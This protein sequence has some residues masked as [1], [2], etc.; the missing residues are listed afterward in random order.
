MDGSPSLEMIKNAGLALRIVGDSSSIAVSCGVYPHDNSDL[1]EELVTVLSA[2]LADAGS[3]ARSSHSI[4]WTLNRD[5]DL[6]EVFVSRWVN[7]GRGVFVLWHPHSALPI[8][9]G[10]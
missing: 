7:G 3:V 6:V 9:P 5:D 8:V 4:S 2:K 1:Y 10:G